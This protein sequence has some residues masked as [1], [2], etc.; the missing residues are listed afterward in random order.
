[1]R[2]RVKGN[3][4]NID[5]SHRK[6]LNRFMATSFV[7]KGFITTTLARAKFIKPYI[8]K[9]VTKAKSEGTTSLR[10]LQRSLDTRAAIDTIVQTV[11]PKFETRNG[12]Y[13][14]LIKLGKRVG[15]NAPLAKLE[16]VE[17]MDVPK[18][19]KKADK[20]K[21]KE[22]TSALEAKDKP[23]EKLKKTKVK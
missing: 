18:D 6:S 19:T 15:D 3:E 16:W 23:L 13:T 8:E 11:A 17:H 21:N 20:K 10:F 22:K 7:E 4:L 12:G 2:H 14:R 1:M 5:T 9:L